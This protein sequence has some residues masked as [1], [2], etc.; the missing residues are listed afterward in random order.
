MIIEKCALGREK[1]GGGS[2]KPFS[3]RVR[4]T[5]R[6]QGLRDTAGRRSCAG[7]SSSPSSAGSRTPRTTS[8]STRTT[9]CAAT[10]SGGPSPGKGPR[11]RWRPRARRAGVC[12]GVGVQRGE[13]GANE[14]KREWRRFL[15]SARQKS[16][17]RWRPVL[18]IM[19]AALSACAADALRKRCRA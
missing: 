9:S 11:S 7:S 5:R 2:E 3:A 8:G 15:P 17:T 6:D 18:P 4:V 13:G 19:C 12:G 16:A 1:A 10:A 14:P